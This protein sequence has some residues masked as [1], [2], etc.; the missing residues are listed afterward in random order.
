MK[1]RDVFSWIARRLPFRGKRHAFAGAAGTRLAAE[2]VFAPLASADQELKGDLVTLRRRT[3]ELARNNAHAARYVELV[4]ENVVGPEGIRLQSRIK[5]ASGDYDRALNKTIEDAW[6]RW[7]RPGTCTVDGRLS[8]VDV[9]WQAAE[10]LERD[11]EALLQMVPGARNGFG[12]ALQP[13]DIDLLDVD[14]NRPRG[15]NRNEIRM[16]VEIDAAGRPVAYHLWSQHPSDFTSPDRMRERVPAGSVVHLFEQRRPGQT[17]GW[18]KLASVMLDLR[19]LGAYREAEIVAARFG[20]AKQVFFTTEGDFWSD[21]NSPEGQV[22]EFSMTA[23]P[24]KYEALPP[25][26]KPEFFDPTHPTTAFDAFDR[27]VLR[28]ISTGL[29]VA[30][31]SLTGDLTDVNYSSIQVGLRPEQT[32][33][34]KRQRWLRDHLHARVYEEWLRWALTAG[35]LDVGRTRY[36]DLLAYEF[37]GRGFPSA[38]PRKDAEAHQMDLGMGLTSRRRIAAERGDDFEEIVADLAEEDRIA[39]QYGVNLKEQKDGAQNATPGND[40][41]PRAGAVRLRA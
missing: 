22:S 7:G 27:A 11:G 32:R 2:W 33:W 8:W 19:Q 17:R 1:L 36:A 24:G 39:E 25:G 40:A 5:N 34:R 37:M 41:T 3:R 12:F 13:L 10:A 29:G 21:P 35:G 16:G 31:A 20:A 15:K 38:D 30:Y 23:E 28:T 9:Q 6:R 14:Y 4:A 26:L 18:P